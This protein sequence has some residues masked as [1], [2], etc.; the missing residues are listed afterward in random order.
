MSDILKNPEEVKT[1]LP[2]FRFFYAVLAFSFFI[3]GFRL[4]FLQIYQGETLRQFS[5]RNHLKEI[6]VEAPRGLILD[7]E[8]RAMVDNRLG[9]EVYLQSQYIKDWDSTIEAVAPL[10]QTP[11]D[12]L[13][14]R[15]TRARK[16]QG[17]YAPIRIKENLSLEEVFRLK[18]ARL[19]IPG[20]DIR[21]KVLRNY[22]LGKN[23]SQVFG[24]VG[25]ISK[26]QLPLFK[27]E[28]PLINFDQGDIV[29]KFGIE[30]LLEEHLHGQNGVKLTQV[31][32]FGREMS[33]QNHQASQE[34]Q[35]LFG[36]YIKDRAA[37]PGNNIVLTLDMDIQQATWNAFQDENKIGGAVVMRADGEILAWVS[38]PG[39]DPNDFL[40]GISSETW[41]KLIN[42]PFKPLRNKV[43]QDH[44]A[45]GSTFKPLVALAGLQERA[46]RPQ[47]IVYCPGALPFG[48]RS[49][50]DHLK[51]GFGNIN[52][53]EALERSSNVYF[54][55]LGI[56]LGIDKMHKYI[57]AMG[58]G[59]KTGIE[60]PR[61]APGLMP[62]TEW[63][64]KAR[65][66]DWHPG[67]NLSV[68]IGQGFVQA[69]PLQLAIA[70]LAV[71]SEGKVVRPYLVKRILSPNGEIIKEEGPKII[72][73][74][75]QPQGDQPPLIDKAHFGPVKEG[76][77]L[78]VNGDRGTARARVR[79]DGV[80]IAGKTG[81]A[82]V[83]G[84]SATEIYAK[85]ENRPIHMRHHGWFVGYAPADN[86]EVVVSVLAEHSC[87][88][89]GGAGPLVRS[90]LY[91]YFQ[92]YHPELNVQIPKGAIL[93]AAQGPAVPQEPEPTDD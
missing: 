3:F 53:L 36:S 74:L 86:P 75:S 19:T 7:R 23:G 63:K 49:F 54:Y 13:D 81:T 47:T 26:K 40:G 84:F 11:V 93:S 85:C 12:K 67:E 43:I 29:G 70:Y 18:R 30:E 10:I 9:Y 68:A 46:I 89:S 82:Q 2:R 72:R 6:K 55:K 44:F 38:A 58:I 33:N 88:G 60:L 76:L 16:Q 28:Y 51:G 59:S 31:D 45:P 25:E 14:Q 15:V 90:I 34:T 35:Q 5:E 24:Y 71:G 42:D 91:H 77:R 21:D 69:T 22:N 87:S 79:L 61:E 57:S 66:E 78:V 73:D 20:L 56:S 4:W 62:S 39:F 92:K 64:R 17:R 27:K 41:Q 8:G 32:A 83:R 52:L 37:I 50:H 1:L 48:N 65:N 80:Q